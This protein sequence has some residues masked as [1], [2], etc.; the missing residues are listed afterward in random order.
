MM[1]VALAPLSL[2]F[3]SQVSVVGLLAN[4]LAIPWVT[5]WVTP[6]ALLGLVWPG[7]WAWAAGAID[8]LA[9]ALTWAASWPWAVWQVPPAPAGVAALGL[10]GAVLLVQRWPWA[11]RVSGIPLLLPVLSWQPARPVP[12]E[13]ELLAADVGQ[14]SAVLLR[15]AQHSLLFDAGPRY[16]RDSDAGH[17]V[18]LPL[19]Q[20]QG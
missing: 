2:L 14:G 5:L 8:I 20:T 12:G 13:F 11:L 16:S 17:R 15:T 6:L 7:F 1:T 18:L 3:F 9:K 4:L 19:L 10:L